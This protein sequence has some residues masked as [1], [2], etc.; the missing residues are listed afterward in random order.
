MPVYG[1]SKHKDEDQVMSKALLEYYA[2]QK[3]S[4]PSQKAKSNSHASFIF[5]VGVFILPLTFIFLTFFD[6]ATWMEISIIG[7]LL[8]LLITPIAFIIVWLNEKRF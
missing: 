7:I 4:E 2:G 8:D 6:P 1:Y 5:W 3:D